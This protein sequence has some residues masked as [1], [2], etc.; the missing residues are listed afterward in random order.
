MSFN[1]YDN[2]SGSISSMFYTTGT[3]T[4]G[5]EFVEVKIESGKKISPIIY[6]KFLK[7]KLKT[8]QNLKLKARIKRLEKAFDKA[9]ENGQDA[10]A[11][12]FLDEVARESR[13]SILWATGY[14]LFIEEKD[15]KKHKYNIKGGHISDTHYEDYT[16]IIPDDVIK[17]KKDA[18]KYFDDFII[19]HYWNEKAK[20]VKKMDPDEKAKMKDP[21]LFGK[22]KE[23]NRWYFIADWED[24]KCDLTF[25]KLIDYLGKKDSEVE[26]QANPRIIEQ[27]MKEK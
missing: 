23:T 8:I 27:T 13:E 17:K 11:K 22:I 24:E 15:I 1:S 21:I 12:K 19:L 26:I 2:S 9:V 4:Y 6:F 3:S 18:E 16:R 14:K 7:S 20:D 5:N 10:L 25:D